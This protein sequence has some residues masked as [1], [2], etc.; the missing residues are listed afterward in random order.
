MLTIKVNGVLNQTKININID[1]QH[2]KIYAIQGPSGIGKTTILNIIAGLKAIN[3]SYIKVGKRVLTDSRHHLNV[4]VQQRRIGYLFQDYQ[5]FPNM[6]VY[7]NITFMTKPSEHINELI[8]TL[9]IEHLL[10]KYPVTLSGGEAQ[11]V[12]LARALSTKPD[13]ILLD[14]PF[15]SL[16]DK[17]KKEGIKLILKIFEAWQIPIIFVTHSNYEA[18]QMAHKIITI[19]DCIQI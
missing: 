13:L 10:E 18:Q 8:H 9:K 17:T 15:S 16:D 6:N 3:Y 7:N 5:L 4:K 14:E 12:A 2:P 11:R 1:D 19:E